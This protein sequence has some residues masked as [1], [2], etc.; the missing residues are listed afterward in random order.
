VNAIR[1]TGVLA[2]AAL[3]AAVA[4]AD[5]KPAEVKPAEVKPAEVKP[6]GGQPAGEK[7]D[8]L[9]F[10]NLSLRL[11]KEEFADDLKRSRSFNEDKLEKALKPAFGRTSKTPTNSTEMLER[12]AAVLAEV[13]RD[14]AKGY[15]PF[16]ERKYEDAVRIWKDVLNPAREEDSYRMA[17]LRY[18]LGEAYRLNNQKL[19]AVFEYRS[20]ALKMPKRFSPAGMARYHAG[21]CFEDLNRKIRATEEWTAFSQA[22][23]TADEK[24]LAEVEEKLKDWTKR[25]GSLSGIIDDA[26]GQMGD[27]KNDLSRKLES[28]K[29]VQE[30]QEKISGLLDDLILTLEEKEKEKDGGGGGGGGGQSGQQGGMA[31]GAPNA[32]AASSS[33]PGGE[34]GKVGELNTSKNIRA[35][36][37]WGRLPPREKERILNAIKVQFPDRYNEIVKEYLKGISGTDAAA[38]K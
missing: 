33:L 31:G 9:D 12:M 2:A 16:R 32:P 38:G 11:E 29:P 21:K 25:F 23:G 28:G 6:A 7:L 27:V 4:R 35:D 14:F 36:D 34:T 26:A 17:V 24:L 5:E 37:G 8:A 10:K 3:L 15:A 13:D 18:H 20:L 22:Y 1:L 30:K 19:E